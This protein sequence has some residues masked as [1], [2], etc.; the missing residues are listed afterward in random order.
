MSK[1]YEALVK[2]EQLRAAQDPAALARRVART[3]EEGETLRAELRVSQEQLAA[4]IERVDTAAGA[5]DELRRQLARLAAQQE[6]L[7]SEPRQLID[8]AI[9]QLREEFH[10]RWVELQSEADQTARLARLEQAHQDVFPALEGIRGEIEELQRRADELHRSH[11]T[12]RQTLGATLASLQ[13]ATTGATSLLEEQQRERQRLQAEL[14]TLRAA[15]QEGGGGAQHLAALGGSI[16]SLS[17]RLEH[18]ETLRRADAE[19]L[20]SEVRTLQQ[21]LDT[22]RSALAETDTSAAAKAGMVESL[23]ADIDALREQ[24]A[25]LDRSDRRPEPRNGE[26]LTQQEP[27]APPVAAEAV[28][29]VQESV[30]SL[31]VTQRALLERLVATEEIQSRSDRRVQDML[32]TLEPLRAEQARSSGA[33]D[34]LRSQLAAVVDSQNR[35]QRLEQEVQGAQAAAEEAGR[36]AAAIDAAHAAS[37]ALLQRRMVEIQTDRGTLRDELGAVQSALTEQLRQVTAGIEAI[38][39]QLK[40][41]REA[42]AR[43]DEIAAGV[44]RAQGAADEAARR[45]AANEEAH[46]SALAALHQKI[47]T[48]HADSAAWRDVAATVDSVLARQQG[49]AGEIDAVRA[50]L[51]RIIEAQRRQQQLFEDLLLA[52][53]SSSDRPLGAEAAEPTDVTSLRRQVVALQADRMKLDAFLENRFEVLCEV[54]DAEMQAKLDELRGKVPAAQSGRINKLRQTVARL[55]AVIPGIRKR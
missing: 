45:I 7:A 22:L 37:L 10:R 39:T 27:G 28:Q 49:S 30:D 25:G 55:A 15:Q 46:S 43:Q 5:D 20:Q 11:Q 29:A 32:G 50:Q 16:E 1:T 44:R 35:Q 14:A 12:E 47:D 42:R 38:R 41:L 9:Q 8:T 48:L 17:Q 6:Q 34:E 21:A 52:P 2:A 3:A 54:L 18:T 24:L 19:R 4:L 23:R 51:A 36:R 31:Q 26:A 53:A 13:Q 40:P 33:I